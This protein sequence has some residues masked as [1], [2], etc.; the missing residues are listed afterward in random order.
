MDLLEIIWLV[1]FVVFLMV[2]AGTVGL[3]CIWFAVGALAALVTSWLG[4]EIWLQAVL[5]LVTSCGALACL[6]P[7]ARKFFVP[8]LTA[9][10]AD[11]LIGKEVMLTESV[12]NLKEAGELSLNGVTWSARSTNGEPIPA[13][14][15]VRV[16]RIEGVRVFVSKA[17]EKAEV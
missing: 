5:F 3:V 14:T 6:R 2:E 10:N 8:K 7:L 9:T 11:S 12:D 1:A 13:G 15:A 16:D 17:P 4:G